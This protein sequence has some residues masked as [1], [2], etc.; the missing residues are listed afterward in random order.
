MS[1]VAITITALKTKHKDKILF[2]YEMIKKP[3]FPRD[4]LLIILLPNLDASAKAP[5]PIDT[6][7]KVL[8]R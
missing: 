2:L 7:L 4:S 3:F 6:F 5:S 1:I 8:K